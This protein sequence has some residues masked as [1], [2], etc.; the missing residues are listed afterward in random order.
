MH[1]ATKF[2][3][4]TT[5]GIGVCILKE[6]L[7]LCSSK[8]FVISM[9]LYIIAWYLPPLRFLIF[10]ATSLVFLKPFLICLLDTYKYPTVR[11]YCLIQELETGIK[12]SMFLD[13]MMRV[14]QCIGR[15]SASR[16]N[17]I[18]AKRE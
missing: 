11:G 8:T 6:L 9:H 15:H 12:A 4:I 3:D 18:L 2:S 14:V 5:R 10:R 1:P 13:D 16:C 17:H 7:E